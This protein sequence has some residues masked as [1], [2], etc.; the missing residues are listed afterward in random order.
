MSG[1]S[2]EAERGS[3]GWPRGSGGGSGDGEWRK[4]RRE[5]REAAPTPRSWPPSP[6]QSMMTASGAEVFRAAERKAA[7]LSGAKC[8]AK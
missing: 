3:V 6:E 1:G 5:E 2:R 7:V 8:T 4:G